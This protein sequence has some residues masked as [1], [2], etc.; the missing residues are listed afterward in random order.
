MDGQKAI[1]STFTD[2]PV[3]AFGSLALFVAFAQRLGMAEML[4]AALPFPVTSPNATPP[5][6]I[7]LA[8]F[9]GVLAGA[10]RFAQLA[11]LRADKPVRPAGPIPEGV[12]PALLHLEP[13]P[14]LVERLPG[15]PEA[16]TG[17]GDVPQP[18]RLLE[19]GR[20]LTDL[21]FRGKHDVGHG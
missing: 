20:P 15:D 3:T 13:P 6:Q 16:S 7:L 12:P 11:I 4:A 10:R 19:P 17:Q 14:P 8:F 1:G 5:H 18:G 21:L 9:A 2:K